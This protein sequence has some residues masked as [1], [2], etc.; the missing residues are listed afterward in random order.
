MVKAKTNPSDMETM[1]ETH[2]ATTSHLVGQV[3]SRA[4]FPVPVPVWLAKVNSPFRPWIVRVI[5]KYC[6]VWTSENFFMM[7]G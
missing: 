7:E 2:M 6:P 1:S 3:R 5:G 4:E